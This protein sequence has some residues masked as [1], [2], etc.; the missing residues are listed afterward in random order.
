MSAYRVS[1]I[2]N[3][4][5]SRGAV[6][7]PGGTK[8]LRLLVDTGSSFTILPVEALEAIGCNPAAGKDHVRL[9]TGNGIVIAPRVSVEWVHVLGRELKAFSVLAHTIPFGQFF[10]GLLG[11]DILTRVQAQINVPQQIIEVT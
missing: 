11:M 2:G 9:I 8:I 1:R 3:L 6:H 10:D 7:G 5:V 4:L